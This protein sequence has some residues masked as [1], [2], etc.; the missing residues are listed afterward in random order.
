MHGHHDHTEPFT[1]REGG[2]GRGRVARVMAAIG[3]LLGSGQT[4]ARPA[5]RVVP[6]SPH[7]GCGCPHW[8][9]RHAALP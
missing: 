1:V 7:R 6:M 8:R 4:A 3:A 2:A 5:G 9:N